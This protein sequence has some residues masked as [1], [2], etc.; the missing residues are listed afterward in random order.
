MLIDS[1]AHVDLP[2]FHDDLPAVLERCREAEVEHVVD[3]LSPFEPDGRETLQRE[4]E[5]ARLPLSFT[6]GVHPHD[7]SRWSHAVA[8]TVQRF[9]EESGAAW[10]EIGLDYHYDHSTPAEQRRVFALQLRAARRAGKPIV[11]HSRE[12]DADTVL[13]LQDES[14]HEVGGVIHCFTGGT[15]LSTGA[16]ELG[17]AI[18]FSGIV[19]FKNA[20]AL[21][22]IARTVPEDRILVETDSPFLAPVPL[23]GKRNE[24]A[25]V[26]KVAEALAE[27]RGAALPLFAAATRRN[28]MR[29]FRIGA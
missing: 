23:R 6:M 24:P 8:D 2:P 20:D 5:R 18:S 3:I 15:A 14:A 11:V 25:N 26:R 28:T 13:M 21:R 27:L 19:T 1:H 29:L 7:A 10:G 9:V 17:F 16:L 12:A 22:E 4:A